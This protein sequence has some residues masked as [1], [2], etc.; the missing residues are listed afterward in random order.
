MPLSISLPT[1]VTDESRGY[2]RVIWMV[3]AVTLALALVEGA[4]GHAVG[5]K[6]LLKD[7]SSFGYDVA[8]NAI[9]ALV[10]GRG[11][12]VERL[13]AL[14]IAALLAFSGFDGLSD[15]W[16]NLQSSERAGLGEVAASNLFGIAAAG[17]AAV[18]LMRFSGS[19]NPLIQATWLNARNDAIAAGLTAFLAVLAG[20]APVRWP[21]YALDLVGVIFS[22][23][24]AATVLAAA[25]R[26]LR[27]AE[28]ATELA[29]PTRSLP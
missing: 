23:Q 19:Q 11:V 28:P 2:R 29:D 5:S 1:Q 22:F 8:L 14:A 25:G 27:T 15:L 10:F 12:R 18:T 3:V 17:F 26:D 4:W 7:A 24:A 6:D 21:E 20:L 9:S 16:T 13:S